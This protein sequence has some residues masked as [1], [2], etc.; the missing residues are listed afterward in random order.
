VLYRIDGE[1]LH[2]AGGL[3]DLPEQV[4]M[5]LGIFTLMPVGEGVSSCSCS[6]T[7]NSPRSQRVT[8][9]IGGLV[10]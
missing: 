4:H 10:G 8:M 3:T 6:R 9:M 2:V 7:Q 5:A 1:I